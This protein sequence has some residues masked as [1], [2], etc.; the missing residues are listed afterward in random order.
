MTQYYGDID[1]S[2]NVDAADANLVLQIARLQIDWNTWTSPVTDGKHIINAVALTCPPAT[3]IAPDAATANLILQIARGQ[4]SPTE[5]LCAAVT[6]TPTVTPTITLTPTGTPTATPTSTPAGTPAVTP[7]VTPT[8][9]PTSTPA[10][11]PAPTPNTAPQC[12]LDTSGAFNTTYYSWPD[13][14]YSYDPT[15][16]HLGHPVWKHPGEPGVSG[17][18]YIYA[19]SSN[20]STVWRQH[21][22]LGNTAG[23]LT[24]GGWVSSAAHEFPWEGQWETQGNGGMYA[25]VNESCPTPTPTPTPTTTPTPTGTPT[26]TSAGTPAATPTPT[27]TPTSTTQSSG[28]TVSGY[29]MEI[30]WNTVQQVVDAGYSSTIQS[31]TAEWDAYTGFYES[32]ATAANWATAASQPI[33][34]DNII[35]I[36]NN[37]PVEFFINPKF[38]N[39]SIGGYYYFL[40]FDNNTSWGPGENDKWVM[41]KTYQTDLAMSGIEKRTSHPEGT[42]QQD[43]TTGGWYAS[44]F[45]DMGWGPLLTCT[46]VNLPSTNHNF[47][48]SVTPTPTPTS[49]YS[50]PTP[51]PT[52]TST[53]T[54]TPTPTPYP[55]GTATPTPTPTGTPAGGGSSGS[56]VHVKVTDSSAWYGGGANVTNVEGWYVKDPG[57]S[58]F[59]YSMETLESYTLSGNSNFKLWV[60]AYGGSQNIIYDAYNMT[61]AAYDS[62]MMG[63]IFTASAAKWVNDNS[64]GAEVLMVCENECISPTPTPTPSAGSASMACN[65]GHG[66]IVTNTGS[67]QNDGYTGLYTAGDTSSTSWWKEDLSAELAWK[68]YNSNGWGLY[69]SGGYPIGYGPCPSP[70]GDWGGYNFD[71][72]WCEDDGT[73]QPADQMCS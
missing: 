9:T 50:S 3:P 56:N 58:Y 14:T 26:S 17:P 44:G 64:A 20:T 18:H 31:M 28:P 55:T 45:Y 63:T 34:G 40:L 49:S 57:T 19:A 27:I 70:S 22:A 23:G 73:S 65:G 12:D 13:G 66:W 33:S 72:T 16:L 61:S 38:H 52:P 51:T 54:P 60:G 32:G 41:K 71:V 68:K 59:S 43:A 35:S 53:G 62:S 25:T 47:G 5:Y 36:N 69:T 4:T 30:N 24:G 11:T 8:G 21:D 2:G 1:Q 6:P 42:D 67:W 15:Q 29:M 7:T 46:S 37:P 39:L 48:G 10:G